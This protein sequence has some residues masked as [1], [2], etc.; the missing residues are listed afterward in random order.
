MGVLGGFWTT[1]CLLS[2]DCNRAH[3]SKCAPT[4]NTTT[5]KQALGL[6]AAGQSATMTGTYTGQFVMEGFLDLKV[7]AAARVVVTRLVALAPTLGVALAAGR[8]GSGSAGG[9]AGGG[10]GGGG[11]STALDSLNQWLNLLQSVQLPFA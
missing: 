10:G 5:T 8:G 11:A 9:G 3:N 1:D 2:C 6:L 7:S 4:R